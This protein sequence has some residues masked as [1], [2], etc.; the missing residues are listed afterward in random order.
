MD[1]DVSIVIVCM[2]NLQNLYPCLDS[3]KKYTTVSYETLV[4]AYLFSEENLRKLR[5]DYPWITIIESNE[6]RGFSE[7]NNL[8]LRQ[9]KG[10]YCFVL[11]DD[12]EMKMDV[13]GGL[14]YSIEKL[15]NEVAIISPNILNRDGT[16]QCCGRP[17]LG[18]KEYILSCF[19]L[20]NE[21]KS[22]SKYVNQQGVFESFNIVGA[23]FLIKTE[24]F[25]KAGWFDEYYFFVPEDIALSMALNKMGYKCYVDA[26]ISIIHYGGMT[27]KSL[28]YIQTATKP[29]ASKGDLHL[30]AR[31]N[32][33]FYFFL[34]VFIFFSAIL[35]C[36]YYRIKSSS[37]KKPNYVYILFIG[38][39]NILQTI[40]RK[41]TPKQIFIHF[42]RKLE[43]HENSEKEV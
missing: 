14:A 16:V 34:L 36:F 20:W 43:T 30:Y 39:L 6:I 25:K 17:Y 31:G 22:R 32:K 21:K 26:D 1:I 15:P 2:N 3:I 10:R 38:H 41:M 35:R 33:F 24:I 40:Y 37:K 12:T 19:N 18:R 27:G 11:N 9:A 8:A 7:N 13:L 42:Y 5:N 23:A 29:A 4:V 28:S